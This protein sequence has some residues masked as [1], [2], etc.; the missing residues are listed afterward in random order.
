MKLVRWSFKNLH[1]PMMRD[2]SGDL[3]CTSAQLCGALGIE[4]KAL[5][6]LKRRNPED[7]DLLS[8]TENGAKEFFLKNKA[9]FGV[10]RVRKDMTLWSEDDM[11]TVAIL[12]RS[13]V[14]RE[15]RKELRQFIKESARK[16]LLAGYVTREEHERILMEFGK[17]VT[18][19]EALKRLL[20]P[21][22]KVSLQ[23]V[24]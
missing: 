5:R 10:R 14:A 24:N 11:I 8:A 3:W 12:S 1:M 23:V 15:F 7:F 2:E 13:A 16:D 21:D 18:E 19:F 22:S 17:M 20:T 6:E 4:P 9:E